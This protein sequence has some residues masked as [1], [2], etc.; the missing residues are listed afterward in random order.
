[1]CLVPIVGSSKRF[2]LAGAGLRLDLDEHAS[3]VVGERQIVADEEIKVHHQAA[4]ERCGRIRGAGLENV[5][6]ALLAIFLIGSIGG[7]DQ[8]VSKYGQPVIGLQSNGG[9]LV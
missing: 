1:M 7:F 9:G 4:D 8:T 2:A 3:D 5:Y 6:H